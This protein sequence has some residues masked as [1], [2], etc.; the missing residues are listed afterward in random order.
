MSSTSQGLV[1]EASA[2]EF[3]WLWIIA[4][5]LYGVGDVLTTMTLVH[6]IPAITEANALIRFAFEQFGTAGLVGVKLTVFFTCL[7]ISLWGSSEDD[8]LLFYLPPVVLSV[9]GAFTTVYNLRLFFGI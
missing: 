9:V 3:T 1:D 8:R 4:T 7:A 6:S 2:R 5:T